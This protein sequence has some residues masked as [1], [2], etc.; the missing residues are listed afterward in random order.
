MNSAYVFIGLVLLIVIA[1]GFAV[2]KNWD[3][4]KAWWSSPKGK[5][6]KPG[7]VMV[8]AIV[9]IWAVSSKA[10][11]GDNWFNHLEMFAGLDV[12]HNNNVFCNNGDLTGNVGLLGNLY[13]SDDRK[14]TFDLSYQHHE[15][16]VL[17]GKGKYEAVGVQLSYLWAED[18]GRTFF[19]YEELFVGIDYDLT[20]SRFCR[21][22][23]PG[24][25]FI[26]SN[27][28]FRFNL[29]R[30]K[31]HELNFKISHHSCAFNQDKPTYDAIGFEFKI[32]FG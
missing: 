2:Y 19:N 5:N 30:Y 31:D 23:Y 24:G 15:C 22:V 4:A 1:L 32:L 29:A 27:I 25:K 12:D 8:F 17:V 13:T 26:T 20:D 28:G 6:V 3:E 11:A 18:R 21:D 16:L 14:F 7:I 10:C 9:V